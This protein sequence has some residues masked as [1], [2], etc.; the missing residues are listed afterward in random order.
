MRK[1]ELT[2]EQDELQRAARAFVEKRLPTSHLRGLRDAKDATHL[3][4]AVWREMAQ[5]GW[6]GI[7]V[8]EKHGGAGLGL[9]E[10]G[11]VMEELGRTL[12]PTPLL[13]TSVIGAAALAAGSEAVRAHLPA[14]AEGERLI[15]L[16]FEEERRF[17]PYACRTTARHAIHAGGW[18]LDGEKTFVLDGPAADLLVVVARTAG[19]SSDREGLTLFVVDRTTAGLTVEPLSMVDSRG[20]ARVR[21]ANVA[22][23]SADIL[24]E[25]DKGADLLDRLLARA[26]A[27]LAAEMLG[28]ADAVFHTT[29]EYL[30]NRHQFGV[31]IG[32][33]Q[34]LK[35]RAAHIFCELELTRSVV[36]A[37]LV[38]VENGGAD[39][40]ALVS[41]AKARASDTF[42]LVA[43]EAIQMHGGI[44]VTDDLDVGFYYKRAK[45]AELTF[46]N[47]AFH[48]DRFA[49]LH[50]Y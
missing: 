49:K 28:A 30:K 47:A 16:A 37:A 6:A 17:A 50:G 25:A 12:A 38:A 36:R 48:R 20:A 5:L 42:T 45:V 3:S 9:V 39:A 32:S 7:A 43:A 23:S 1:F 41:A 22:I 29:I 33:F 18:I 14:L 27:A 31:A 40:D 21:L 46:G 11:L 15:A 2:P 44:G 35:H 24:G 13:A 4:R 34:G 8:D 26:T 10:L 19:D